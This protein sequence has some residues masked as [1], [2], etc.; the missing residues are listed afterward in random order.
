MAKKHTKNAHLHE[1][2]EKCKPNY[3]EV[4]PIPVGVAGAKKTSNNKCWLAKMWTKGNPTHCHC[5]C[6]LVHSLWKSVSKVLKN[7]KKDK[8][9]CKD[10]EST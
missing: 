3:I 6:E 1:P 7:I 5:R 4:L 2:S 9:H 8:I 10:Y